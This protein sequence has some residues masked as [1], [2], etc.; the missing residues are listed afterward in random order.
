M[1]ETPDEATA[2]AIANPDI[3]TGLP[4]LEQLAVD[5]QARGLSETVVKTVEQPEGVTVRFGRDG[6]LEVMQ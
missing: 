3:P 6:K 5:M 2:A 1:T 4:D